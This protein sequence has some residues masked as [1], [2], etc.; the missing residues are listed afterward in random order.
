MYECVR[1]R[2]QQAHSPS[3]TGEPTSQAAHEDKTPRTGLCSQRRAIR[4]SLRT[5]EGDTTLQP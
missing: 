1:G 3:C 5:S 2:E 4:L